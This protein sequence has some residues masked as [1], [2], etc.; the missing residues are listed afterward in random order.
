MRSLFIDEETEKTVMNFIP[1]RQEHKKHVKRNYAKVLK[2]KGSKKEDG[3][4]DSI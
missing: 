3:A 2:K 4:I 1:Q